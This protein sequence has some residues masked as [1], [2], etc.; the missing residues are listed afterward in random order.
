MTPRNLE[1]QVACRNSRYGTQSALSAKE[2]DFQAC[3]QP[4]PSSDSGGPGPQPLSPSSSDPCP[5]DSSDSGVWK[6]PPIA[7]SVQ[8]DLA[9]VES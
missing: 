1:I 6:D 3:P 7:S 4:F 2:A 9:T 5:R 8:P